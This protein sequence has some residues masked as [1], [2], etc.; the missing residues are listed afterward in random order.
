MTIS[1]NRKKALKANKKM[2]FRSVLVDKFFTERYIDFNMFAK[3]GPVIGNLESL[4]G[5]E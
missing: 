2:D 1:P 5:A 3:I 4:L